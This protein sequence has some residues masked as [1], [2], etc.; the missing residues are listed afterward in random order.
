MVVSNSTRGRLLLDGDS[1]ARIKTNLEIVESAP[2]LAFS[3]YVSDSLPWCDCGCA[4]DSDLEEETLVC[5]WDGITIEVVLPYYSKDYLRKEF[6]EFLELT[7]HA[8]V[9]R[10]G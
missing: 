3:N 2:N 10:N 1:I 7:H 6:E 5:N 9:P 4:L 8:S